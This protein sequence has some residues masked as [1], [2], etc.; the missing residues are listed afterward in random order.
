M[1]HDALKSHI[2][3]LE[4][5]LDSTHLDKIDAITISTILGSIKEKGYAE[6]LWNDVE[7]IVKLYKDI[8]EKAPLRKR[9]EVINKEVDNDFIAFKKWLKG[10]DVYKSR[11]GQYVE[12]TTS[13]RKKYTFE[14]IKEFFFTQIKT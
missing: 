12:R 5:Y 9:L 11:Q 13:F 7:T 1:N 3:K 8:I 10:K 2:E 14:E 6:Y 4:S